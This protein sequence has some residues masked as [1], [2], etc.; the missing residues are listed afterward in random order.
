MSINKIFIDTKNF[1]DKSKVKIELN[2]E[3][4][5]KYKKSRFYHSKYFI[6]VK[7][8]QMFNQFNNIS[9][10][11][12]DRII[13]YN[14]DDSYAIPDDTITLDQGSFLLESSIVGSSSSVPEFDMYKQFKLNEGN[15]SV[16]DI[17][18]LFNNNDDMKAINLSVSFDIYN[19]KFIFK[20]EGIE[21]RYILFG[22]SYLIFG[23]SEKQLFRLKV[24]NTLSSHNS[25][26]V[27]GDTLILFNLSTDSDISL[28]NSSYDNI[29]KKHFELNNIF[30]I[31]PINVLTG[32]IIQ[33][34]RQ[35]HEHIE[36][37]FDHNSL[38]QFTIEAYN[39]DKDLLDMS[40]F[41]MELEIIEK[42]ENK[43]LQMILILL[44][45]IIE[46]LV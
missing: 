24:D 7:Q 22:G 12:N 8:F 39:Q 37:N 4:I 3:Y 46:L 21:D 28:K 25:V 19:N 15:P 6:S 1:S 26:N 42:K 10:N 9:A 13:I 38:R 36:I 29:N 44:R 32:D 14:L 17:V 16:S 45:S 35:C 33:Y 40:D 11:K 34:I 41:F 27:Q 5:R 18:N 43:F 30:Y 20:N 31:Q 23:F 2:D